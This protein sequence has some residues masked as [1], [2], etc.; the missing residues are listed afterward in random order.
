MWL[1]AVVLSAP[2][3]NFLFFLCFTTIWEGFG[4]V[5]CL[6]FHGLHYSTLP[7]NLSARG[8]EK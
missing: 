3:F 6:V 8:K 5:I 4:L 2:L 7:L 1:V